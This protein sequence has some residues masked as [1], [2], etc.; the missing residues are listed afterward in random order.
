MLRPYEASVRPATLRCRLTLPIM[1]RESSECVLLVDGSAG[2]FRGGAQRILR[3]PPLRLPPVCNS[4]AKRLVRDQCPESFVH[5]GALCG[6][7]KYTVHLGLRRPNGEN[8]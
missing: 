4:M 1:L 8:P 3:R 7:T 6:E 2:A 5:V